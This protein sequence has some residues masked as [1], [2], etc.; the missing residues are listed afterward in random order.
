M[1]SVR[2]DSLDNVLAVSYGIIYLITNYV[3]NLYDDSIPVIIY[4]I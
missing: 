1:D 4:L 3:V 2:A